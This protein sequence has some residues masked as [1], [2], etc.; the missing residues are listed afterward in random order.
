MKT[1]VSR[2]LAGARFGESSLCSVL[3]QLEC[4]TLVF[5]LFFW[6]LCTVPALWVSS[7]HEHELAKRYPRPVTMSTWAACNIGVLAD[8]SNFDKKVQCCCQ[9]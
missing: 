3:R 2:T 7:L 8:V 5:V 4:S 9:P 1:C 6:L